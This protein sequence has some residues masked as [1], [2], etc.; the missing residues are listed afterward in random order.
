MNKEQ[1]ISKLA[2]IRETTKVEAEKNLLAV[3]KLMEYCVE[4]KDPLKLTG[5][6][7]M[8]VVER[9]ERQGNNPRTRE[10][11]TIPATKAVRFKTYSILKD[12]AV[13]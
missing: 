1:A 10:K 3:L 11:I 4:N 12:L 5:Y 7:L 9:A 8:E 6:F 13:K 2:E